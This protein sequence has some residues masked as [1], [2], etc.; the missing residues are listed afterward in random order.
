MC[1]GIHALGLEQ[2]VLDPQEQLHA[3][4]QDLKD[5][6]QV[7][8]CTLAPSCKAELSQDVLTC[9]DEGDASHSSAAGQVVTR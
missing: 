4:E 5:A 8:L 9:R 1:A 6:L 7:G 2:G 3:Q